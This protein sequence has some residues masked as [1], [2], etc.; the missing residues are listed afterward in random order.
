MQWG[1]VHHT[2][3]WTEFSEPSKAKKIWWCG[4]L[5]FAVL[6][7]LC[8]GVLFCGIK[9]YNTNV[10]YLFLISFLLSIFLFLFCPSSI[11]HLTASLCSVTSVRSHTY[12][13]PGKSGGGT[14]AGGLNM[15]VQKFLKFGVTSSSSSTFLPHDTSDL[16]REVYAKVL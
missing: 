4:V 9:M 12:T 6:L 5:W 15:S 13:Y 3:Q 7:V 1:V 2:P 11:L 10:H 8:C 16:D 14:S